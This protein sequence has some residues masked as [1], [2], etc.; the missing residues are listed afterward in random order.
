MGA[1]AGLT[2]YPFV[3]KYRNKEGGRVTALLFC[4]LWQVS[5]AFRAWVI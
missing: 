4:S 5:Y 1:V 2:Y 3:L